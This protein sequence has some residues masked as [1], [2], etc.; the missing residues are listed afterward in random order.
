MMLAAVLTRCH[1]RAYAAALVLGQAWMLQRCPA[2][3]LEREEARLEVAA[4]DSQPS[5]RRVSLQDAGDRSHVTLD[6]PAIV[7]ILVEPSL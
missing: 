6:L 5:R 1:A 2:V 4:V 3:A 7:K